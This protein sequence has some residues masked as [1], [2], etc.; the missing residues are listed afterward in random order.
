MIGIRASAGRLIGSFLRI[1]PSDSKFRQLSSG[2]SYI[3]KNV[4]E[5]SVLNGFRYRFAE[6]KDR[7]LLR[8]GL[9]RYFFPEDPISASHRDGPDYV[10]DD[11]EHLLDMIDTDQ[12]LLALDESTGKLAGFC[13]A[14]Y[15]TPDN[16]DKL[17]AE[18][19][20]ARTRKNRDIMLLMAHF[21]DH[22]RVC[23]RFEVDQAF[24][25]QYGGV[26]PEFRGHALAS[27][28]M[29]KHFQV[30][31]HCGVRVFSGDCNGPY[32]AKSC[33]RI[34]MKC[35]YK[36]SYSDYRDENGEIVFHGKK[37]YTDLKCYGMMV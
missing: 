33:E 14:S 10:E 11:M 29:Q 30:A 31:L 19:A 21:A 2:Q 3:R 23:E 22:T 8:D 4:V 26:N 34:G 1:R 27:V 25:I 5:P 13:G 18:A 7:E 12:V 9:E 37:G 28:M 32:M 17:R 24:H 16:V 15:I 36:I 20:A 6:S 35:L